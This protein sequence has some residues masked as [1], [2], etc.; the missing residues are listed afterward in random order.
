[1]NVEDVCVGCSLQITS[2]ALQHVEH[3][4]E[5]VQRLDKLESLLSQLQSFVQKRATTPPPT[6][7]ETENF[8][9]TDA[10]LSPT[11]ATSG[12]PSI[13]QFPYQ[14]VL[15]FPVGI[16]APQ[17]SMQMP[18]QGEGQAMTIPI[19]HLTTT[20]SLFCLESIRSLIGDYPEDFFFQ[21]E[22]SRRYVRET[23]NQNL[24]QM[25]NSLAADRP[26]V[27]AALE[28]FF[29]EIHPHYPILDETKF[30]IFFDAVLSGSLH[31]EIDAALCLVILALGELIWHSPDSKADDELDCTFFTMAENILT[32]QSAASFELDTSLPSGLVYAAIYLCYLQRPLQAWKLIHMASTQLQLIVSQ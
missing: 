29:F 7:Q 12:I 5:I 11:L 28:K 4:G 22:S 32:S 25:L 23:P 1:M 8:S 30:P 2:T 27:E 3:N 18:V 26:R 17:I 6:V 14:D 16:H 10:Y 20:G 24:T 21:I 19:G 31:R 13:S 9:V 15:A